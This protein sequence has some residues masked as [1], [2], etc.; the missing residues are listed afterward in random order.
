MSELGQGT[1]SSLVRPT[2]FEPVAFGSGGRRSIQLSYGRTFER[3]KYGIYHSR[4]Q[5]PFYWAVGHASTHGG[6][7]GA[8][9]GLQQFEGVGA[10]RV[11]VPLPPTFAT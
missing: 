2:G 10:L 3:G 7:T 1:G 9:T 11:L 4:G 8:L 6:V 5:P